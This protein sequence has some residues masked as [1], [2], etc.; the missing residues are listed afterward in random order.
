[1]HISL[2]NGV[3]MCMCSKHYLGMYRYNSPLTWC[4]CFVNG[5]VVA[6]PRRWGT[7]IIVSLMFVYH[8][9]NT[10]CA[11]YVQ[12]TCGF[13]C[14]HITKVLGVHVAT[15][16]PGSLH[17]SL[18]VMKSCIL[19]TAGTWSTPTVSG[20]PPPPLAHF[21]FDLYDQDHAVV[22]GGWT[23]GGG[24]S[25]DVYIL[26]ILHWVGDSDTC[27]THNLFLLLASKQVTCRYC[28]L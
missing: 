19:L 3:I 21:S 24:G 23:K 18:H 6:M 15:S 12:C 11:Y 20:T 5:S 13:W 22:Y 9:C 8:L 16:F 17:F 26:D 28:I 2:Y 4:V 1:M 27:T 7:P 10:T 25:E 14:A